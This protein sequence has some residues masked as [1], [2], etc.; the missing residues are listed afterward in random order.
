M[1]KT[2]VS[3]LMFLFSH[4]KFKNTLR[5]F[6]KSNNNFTFQGCGRDTICAGKKVEVSTQPIV[7]MFMFRYPFDSIHWKPHLSG[8]NICSIQPSLPFLLGPSSIRRCLNLSLKVTC[9]FDRDESFSSI[10]SPSP[11]DPTAV[12]TRHHQSN[13]C[14]HSQLQPWQHNGGNVN[15]R[16]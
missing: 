16:V 1:K 6:G 13:H 15:Q 7:S 11:F 10:V 9:C 2:S 5:L 3:T 8:S 14:Y 12:L 4:M